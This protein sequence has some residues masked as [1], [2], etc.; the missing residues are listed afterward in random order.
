MYIVPATHVRCVYTRN[1]MLNNKPTNYDL[2]NMLFEFAYMRHRYELN[3]CC[4]GRFFA[5]CKNTHM[6]SKYMN[7]SEYPYTRP[8]RCHHK[9]AKKPTH[10]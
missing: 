1:Y 5:S 8:R 10:K 7:I 4:M 3:I 6:T 9:P 2:M